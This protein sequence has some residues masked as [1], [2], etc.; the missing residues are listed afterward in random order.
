MNG[1]TPQ[2][3]NRKLKKLNPRLWVD[4]SKIAFPYSKEYPTCGLYIDEKFIMGVPQKF[5]P[6]WTVAGVDME[7]MVK[8]NQ[9]DELDYML[10]KGFIPEGKDIEER[11]LW[12]GYRAILSH[13]CKLGH[14]D[15]SRAE[16]SF[17]C[18][19]TPGRKEYPRNFVQLKI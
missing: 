2:D 10:D 12:R 16:K 4:H 19:I 7:R 11:L 1:M 17:K 3:F 5:V 13:L 6:E 15:K 9:N 18:E 8:K 14:I